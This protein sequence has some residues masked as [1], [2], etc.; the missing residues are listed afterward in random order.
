MKG[1]GEHAVTQSDFKITESFSLAESCISLS[2]HGQMSKSAIDAYLSPT[3][4]EDSASD[5]QCVRI[6]SQEDI[7][8]L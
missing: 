6:W 1:S 5:T 2:K 4:S 7:L 3:F 8:R